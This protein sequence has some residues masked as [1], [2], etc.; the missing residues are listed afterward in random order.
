MANASFVPSSDASP[1]ADRQD[2]WPIPDDIV[3]AYPDD[4]AQYVREHGELPEDVTFDENFLCVWADQR[5]FIHTRAT[6][7]LAHVDEGVGFGMWVEVTADDF[8]L[9]LNALEDDALYEE[10]AFEGVLA[11]DWPGFPGSLGLRVA[12]RALA[13]GDKVHIEALLAEEESIPAMLHLFTLIPLDALP[14]LREYLY[15]RL[16]GYFNSVDSEPS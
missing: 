11:N 12:V 2:D 1:Y 4:L 5:H 8:S 10:L 15:E 9:F 13:A 6:L 3:C 16:P 14:A 7:P